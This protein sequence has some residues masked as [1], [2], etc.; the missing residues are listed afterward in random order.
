MGEMFGLE[1]RLLEPVSMATAGLRA[2]RPAMS[3]LST[4]KIE[5]TLEVELNSYADDIASF[6]ARTVKGTRTVE[7]RRFK[8]ERSHTGGR[9]G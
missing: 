5:R 1:P 7:S 4:G 2:P 8:H 3:C 9:D 6:Y